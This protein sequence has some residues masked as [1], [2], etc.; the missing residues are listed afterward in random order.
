[1]WCLMMAILSLSSRT[2]PRLVPDDCGHELDA[3]LDQAMA[4]GA[5][6]SHQSQ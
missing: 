1:M 3:L 6:V 4:A 2:I 5:L